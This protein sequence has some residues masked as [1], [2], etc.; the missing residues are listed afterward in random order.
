MSFYPPPVSEKF[1]APKYV[2]RAKSA[3]AVG[4]NATFVCGAVLR[5]TL[6]IDKESKKITDA[7]FQTDGCGFLIAAAEVLA[8]K[9]SGKNL[10][11]LHG[12]DES[13]L[14]EQIENELGD[15]PSGRKHCLKLASET[16]HSAF[17]DFRAAQIEEWAGEKALICTCFGVAEERIEKLVA[18]NS[19]RT[20]EAVTDACNAGGGCGSCR[21]L[22]QEIIDSQEQEARKNF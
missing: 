21:I 1:H 18:E 13:I 19:L 4:T 7:K 17:N 16:L 3:N 22:I 15:F 20:V 11:A 14:M 5:F 12:L 2:G 6:T 10:A 8:E 9:I